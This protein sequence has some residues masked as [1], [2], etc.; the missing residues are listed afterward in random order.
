MKHDKLV[1]NPYFP[2]ATWK[3]CLFRLTFL[4]GSYIEG[5]IKGDMTHW[6]KVV[7]PK[8]VMLAERLLYINTDALMSMEEVK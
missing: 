1:E 4:N 8:T 3:D 5:R 6:L 7:I 2:E